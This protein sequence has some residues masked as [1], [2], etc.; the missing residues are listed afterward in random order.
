MKTGYSSHRDDTRGGGTAPAKA[1]LALQTGAIGDPAGLLAIPPGAHLFIIE[2]PRRADTIIEVILEK[3]EFENHVFKGLRCVAYSK[4]DKTTRR[5]YLTAAWTGK[6]VSGLDEQ[7]KATDVQLAK[8][9]IKEVHQNQED[10]DK[11]TQ[12]RVAAEVRKLVSK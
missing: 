3:V 12:D 11:A 5:L 2:D 1:H 10:I 4:S 9:G 6:H 8:Q 7:Q